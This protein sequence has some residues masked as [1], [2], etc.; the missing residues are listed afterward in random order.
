MR[1]TETRL[2]GRVKGLQIFPFSLVKTIT[3]KETGGNGRV[4][5]ICV[6]RRRLRPS[7]E[8]YT[9]RPH[10]AISK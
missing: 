9:S 5:F 6:F 2:V 1:K 10:T 4:D 8:I 3:G 7:P